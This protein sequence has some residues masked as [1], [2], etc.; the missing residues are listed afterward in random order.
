MTFSYN[1]GLPNPPDDPAD[2]VAGMQTNTA[3]ISNWVAVDHVGFNSAANAGGK[4]NQIQFVKNQAVAA[5][6]SGTISEL[7]SNVLSVGGPAVP[8][9]TNA[10]NTYQI[11]LILTS[12]FSVSSNGYF[13]FSGLYFQ[14]GTKTNASSSGTVTFPINFPNNCFNV[15]LTAY[16]VSSGSVNRP[17]SV[18]T[19]SVT[20]FTY[21]INS[22]SSTDSLFWFAIGN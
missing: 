18:L 20:N 13:N 10:I 5:L 14:W 7:F 2:D 19:T 9:W 15:Q 8:C 1:S 17:C 11:P 4:H 12:G 22:G 6:P 21:G 3:T 16:T